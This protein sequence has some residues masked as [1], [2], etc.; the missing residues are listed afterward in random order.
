MA[1]G[2]ILGYL[3]TFKQRVTYACDEGYQIRGPLYRQCQANGKWG[4][5]DPSCDVVN[6]GPLQKP[7]HGDIIQQVGT[8][9]GNS[10]VFDCTGKG[11]EIRG[12]KVRTC[13]SDGSWSGLPTTCELV[14]CDDPGTPVNG[15]RIVSKGLVYGGSLRFKCNRDYTLM[16]GMSEIIYCQANKRWTASVPHCLAPCRDPGVPRQ[17][18][19]IGDD[20]RHD[21]KVIFSCPN[22]YLMEGVGEISCSNGT[23]SNSV[24]TCKG[25]HHTSIYAFLQKIEK[26]VDLVINFFANKKR[27]NESAR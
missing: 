3:Y 8:T 26:T 22:D 18:S 9:F 23:W 2:R 6:C 20:F 16:K 5:D 27:A 7:D 12:S 13:Q 25:L 15:M 4:G 10:I 11:Y 1:N 17:G 19:R 21:S 24:P 14:K